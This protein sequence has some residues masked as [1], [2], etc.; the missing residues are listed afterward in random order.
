MASVNPSGRSLAERVP[1]V[2]NFAAL[3]EAVALSPAAY[4]VAAANNADRR[5]S[6]AAVSSQRP[7]T[8]SVPT[9]V[10]PSSVNAMVSPQPSP[11]KKTPSQGALSE[12]KPPKSLRMRSEEAAPKSHVAALPVAA[13]PVAAPPVRLRAVRTATAAPQ[14]AASAN[15]PAYNRAPRPKFVATKPQALVAEESLFTALDEQLLASDTVAIRSTASA[16]NTPNSASAADSAPAQEHQTETRPSRS[17]HAD[18][19][20]ERW[21]GPKRKCVTVSVRLSPADAK[22][23]RRRASESQLSVSD[24]MRSCVL[25][26]DQL[27]AQVKQALAEMKMRAPESQPAS[28]H[29][30][31]DGQEAEFPSARRESRVRS[32]L[33]ALRT[34]MA[35]AQATQN[36]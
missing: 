31:S 7:R 27:R 25:E 22:M 23:L 28:N 15:P 29:E 1:Q 16:T 36:R 14:P 32:W 21:P 9:G 4:D 19:S 17:A 35:P 26:A 5:K 20:W 12:R 10:S 2:A 30:E 11:K 3:L 6:N 34:P 13:P 18:E 33:A 24:Y 8:T